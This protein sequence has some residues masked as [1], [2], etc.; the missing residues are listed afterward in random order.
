MKEVINQRNANA[1]TLRYLCASLLKKYKDKLTY[2][3]PK[4]VNGKVT[5]VEVVFKEP[6]LN[7]KVPIS[8]HLDG[9]DILESIENI[10]LINF[11]I[12]YLCQNQEEQ[13]TTN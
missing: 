12:Q 5:S 8:F 10:E 7:A 1:H 11:K 6:T 3:A 13:N 4:T 2:I 9:V